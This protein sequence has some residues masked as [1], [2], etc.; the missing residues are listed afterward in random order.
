MSK[1]FITYIVKL[2]DICQKLVSNQIQTSIQAEQSIRKTSPFFFFPKK[3]I[4]HNFYTE[5][6]IFILYQNDI[7]RL[8]K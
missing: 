3:A 8:R 1:S 2:Y 7:F 4:W 5:Q 6:S